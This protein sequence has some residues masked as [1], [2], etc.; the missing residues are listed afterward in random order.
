MI[1]TVI[2][3]LGGVAFFSYIMENFMEIIKNYE[4]KMGFTDN[5]EA[6]NDWIVSLERFTNKTP[7]NGSM[8][9][10]IMKD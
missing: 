10:I 4:A 6:L 2:V 3:M 5:S 9:E 1:Q 7:L 8:V